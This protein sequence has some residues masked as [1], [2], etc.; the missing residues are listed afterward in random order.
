MEQC[1]RTK[2]ESLDKEKYTRLKTYKCAK[3]S[4]ES[5]CE[6]LGLQA[7][8]ERP[9]TPVGIPSVEF[10]EKLKERVHMLE[11]EKVC[12]WLLYYEMHGMHSSNTI[13]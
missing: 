2:L 8:E 3:E 7:G 1:L 5:L 9:R 13:V 4:E 10:L 12:R 6:T 11:E